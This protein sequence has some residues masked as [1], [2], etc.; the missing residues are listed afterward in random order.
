MSVEESFD[1]IEAEA[2]IDD[3]LVVD[4]VW[5]VETTK[6]LQAALDL[7]QSGSIKNQPN[8]LRGTTRGTGEGWGW[9]SPAKAT[10]DQTLVKLQLAVNALPTGFMDRQTIHAI[11]QLVGLDKK[12]VLDHELV[13]AVQLALNDNTFLN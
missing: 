13:E 10:P 8:S 2:A 5:G 3:A 1:I 9:T 12:H 7:D 4:G 11:A 6:A